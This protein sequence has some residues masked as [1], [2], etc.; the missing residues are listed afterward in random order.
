M[1]SDFVRVPEM[2]IPLSVL[3]LDLEPSTAGWAADLAV[4]GIAI[5]LDDLG[6][7]SLP[8]PRR[9][10]LSLR[11]GSRWPGITRWRSSV[12]PSW[13]E[14]LARLRPGVPAH[15]IPDGVLPAAAM[16]QAAHDTAPR[17]QSVVESAFGDPDELVMHNIRDA[18][19]DW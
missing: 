2:L 7:A 17:R 13:G 9:G 5:H 4:K 12:S 8:V 11:S 16:L 15:S 3:S 14:R 1:S 10:G 6:R 18:E 19:E